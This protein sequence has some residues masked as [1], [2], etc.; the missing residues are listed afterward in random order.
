MVEVR[1]SCEGH[2]RYS[3]KMTGKGYVTNRLLQVVLFKH[4]F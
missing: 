1:D 4:I 3:H 2:G